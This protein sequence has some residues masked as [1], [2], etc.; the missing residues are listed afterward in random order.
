MRLKERI[1]QEKADEITEKLLHNLLRLKIR[2]FCLLWLT[3][4][5]SPRA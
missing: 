5:H 2:V 3:Q 4:V 1:G